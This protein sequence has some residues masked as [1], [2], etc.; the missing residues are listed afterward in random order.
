MFEKNAF[1]EVKLRSIGNFWEINEF[2]GSFLLSQ[3]YIFSCTELRQKQ[4][5]LHTLV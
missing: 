5:I 3:L 4:R 2:A 1:S